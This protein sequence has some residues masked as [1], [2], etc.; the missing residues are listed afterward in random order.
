M[1]KAAPKPAEININL[2]PGGEKPAGTV[3]TAVHWALTVGRFLVIL[4]EIIAISI[5]VLSIKLS[6]DKQGLKEDIQVLTAQV[7]TEAEFENE[8]RFVQNR[9]NEI[10]GLRAAHFLN[11]A[12]I[13]E[14][15]K[16]LPRG[17]K[18]DSLEISKNQVTFSGSFRSPRELQTLISSFSQSQKIV[19]LNIS[20]LEHP[21]EKQSDFTFSADALIVSE[22]FATE[23]QNG[24]E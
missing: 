3:G 15:L 10:K 11:N 23:V 13:A 8:F 18:L 1:A 16:L 24:G 12:V 5:F 7:D 14:L 9:I 4:T 22:G 2:M 21:T 17:M 6:T 19:G 20:N